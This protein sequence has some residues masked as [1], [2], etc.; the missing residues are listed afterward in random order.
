[1][2]LVTLIGQGLTLPA[3][4]RRVGVGGLVGRLEDQEISARLRLARAALRELD[5]IGERTG[6]PR[7]AL[8]RVRGLYADRIERLERHHALLVA[9]GPKQADDTHI[10]AT[11]RLIAELA[12]VERAEL[13]SLQNAAIVDNRLARR[14]QHGLDTAHPLR[15][16]ERGPA[17]T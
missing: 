17:R 2:I 1:V 11:R 13:Q 6:A 4:V 10:Q 8:E 7:D 5:G 9:S 3:L 12:D 15:D 16:S 14:L